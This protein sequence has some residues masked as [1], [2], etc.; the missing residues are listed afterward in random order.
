MQNIKAVSTNQYGS[1]GIMALILMLLIGVIGTGMYN[2]S[3]TDL[4][5]NNNLADGVKAQYLAEEGVQYI[6]VRLAQESVL[7]DRTGTLYEKVFNLKGK[8]DIKLTS[9]VT[10]GNGSYSYVISWPGTVA[11]PFMIVTGRV[12][13]AYRTIT[14]TIIMP[15]NSPVFD[16]GLFGGGGSLML[17]TNDLVIEGS[18]R[19]NTRI[20]IGSGT[21]VRGDVTAKDIDNKGRVLGGAVT[22]NAQPIDTT[23]LASKYSYSPAGTAWKGKNDQNVTLEANTTIAAGTYHIEGDLTLRDHVELNA[24]NSGM[25]IIYVSGNCKFGT[26]SK[27][28]DGNFM[29]I[30]NGMNI[31]DRVEFE[32][33]LLISANNIVF[34]ADSKLTGSAVSLKGDINFNGSSARV[35]YDSVVHDMAGSG[36]NG[37]STLQFGNWTNHLY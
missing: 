28:K 23:D 3:T 27:I 35:T 33:A 32:K 13:S 7:A 9:P 1:V 5:I 20:N 2:L 19:A 14:R 21:E 18:V 15:S 36:G 22:S 6:S 10:K 4:K 34:G 17:N 11:N 24:E 29:I 12:N 30:S 25:V 16:Y 31:D 8:S 26:D 37:S